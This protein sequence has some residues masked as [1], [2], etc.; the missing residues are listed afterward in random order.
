MGLIMRLPHSLSGW[1]K[2]IAS[3]PTALSLFSSGRQRKQGRL[4]RV[5]DV[6]LSLELF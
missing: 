4:E 5:V 1:C 3:K 2:P 6:R